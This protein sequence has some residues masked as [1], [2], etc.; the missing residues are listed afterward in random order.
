MPTLASVRKSWMLETGQVIGH[1]QRTGNPLILNGMAPICL[2]LR[3][4][5]RPVAA[6]DFP[7]IEQT[8][9]DSSLE[10]T[11]LR[12]DAAADVTARKLFP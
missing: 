7:E 3:R 5:N 4:A 9:N 11:G 1:C 12:L 6:L 2:D 8:V 10:G